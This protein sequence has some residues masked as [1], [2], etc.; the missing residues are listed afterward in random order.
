MP[1]LFALSD[2]GAL[3]IPMPAVGA[4]E[5]YHHVLT[6]LLGNIGERQSFN[7]SIN[8]HNNPDSKQRESI[9]AIKKQL[10]KAATDI[11]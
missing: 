9:E 10:K 6:L 11:Q 2:F 3:T 4:Q 7:I 5:N 8:K 1:L